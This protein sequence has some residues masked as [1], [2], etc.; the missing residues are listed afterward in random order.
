MLERWLCAAEPRPSLPQSN[1]FR[2]GRLP[3]QLDREQV[4]SLSSVHLD[5]QVVQSIHSQPVLGWEDVAEL[6]SVT[7]AGPIIAS[8]GRNACRS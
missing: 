4:S 7:I 5:D 6:Y 2:F 8:P 3:A 1:G